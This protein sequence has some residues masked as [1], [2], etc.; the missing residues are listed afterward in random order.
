MNK[1]NTSIFNIVRSHLQPHS[2]NLLSPCKK[3]F[4][5]FFAL[6]FL[7]PH[8]SFS[9]CNTPT[10]ALEASDPGN[11]LNGLNIKATGN[12]TA[13]RWF[14]DGVEVYGETDS[15]INTSPRP[16]CPKVSHYCAQDSFSNDQASIQTYK[17][18]LNIIDQQN[19]QTKTKQESDSPQSK[20]NSATYLLQDDHPH[21][22]HLSDKLNYNSPNQQI[23]STPS[24]LSLKGTYLE[25]QPV[26]TLQQRKITQLSSE[27]FNNIKSEPVH[28]VKNLLNT[29]IENIISSNG[30]SPNNTINN[31]D[32]QALP[33]SSP[34]LTYIKPHTI[35]EFMKTNDY[36]KINI[37]GKGNC[38]Y[39]S[40]YI[41]K[42]L[43]QDSEFPTK[44]EFE[45]GVSSL[46]QHI[47]DVYFNNKIQELEQCGSLAGNYQGTKMQNFDTF[48]STLINSSSDLNSSLP[49]ESW[50]NHDTMRWFSKAYNIPIYSI[51]YSPAKNE[52]SSSSHHKYFN[53]NKDN[54]PAKFIIMT[55]SEWYS[56]IILYNVPVILI[57]NKHHYNILIK[58]QFSQESNWS[59]SLEHIFQHTKK[60]RKQQ[61]IQQFLAPTNSV[62]TTES[63][64]I[65]TPTPTVSSSSAFSGSFSPSQPIVAVSSS[66]SDFQDPTQL[67]S[68]KEHQIK[69]ELIQWFKMS[70]LRST[71]TLSF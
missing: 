5:F 37:V 61:K 31:P 47:A 45:Q 10:L 57:Y 11:C 1:K 55:Y 14:L 38:Q 48:A 8:L 39:F 13:Y 66:D 43:S 56:E 59:T 70:N 12:Y 23:T 51:S 33:S 22:N 71:T 19:L 46:K 25:D 27:T 54:K 26:D 30:V 4:L 49:L 68:T 21:R 17:F 44:H 2:I 42:L 7:F 60:D 50:G 36:I 62:I 32:I 16:P 35:R 34:P 64:P 40:L 69:K 18:P 6:A 28:I 52:F 67:K 15:I 65:S 24:A 58:R 63:S 53:D 41:L 20:H 3:T 9:Q 29:I